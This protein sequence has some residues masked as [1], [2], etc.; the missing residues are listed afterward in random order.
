M[1]GQTSKDRRDE[2]AALT[3]QEWD[4]RIYSTVRQIPRGKVAAYGW[5]AERTG[6]PRGARRVGR[7]LRTL[8]SARRIPWHRVVNAQGRI[9]LPAG[10]ASA[11]KQRELL[12]AEGIIFL[13]HRIDLARFGWR[14]SL[15]EYLWR[16]S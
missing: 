16:P 5:I 8:P 3:P 15:D 2:T 10:S 9:S 7:A 4:E 11:R 1:Q 12:M 14:E 13:N 6:L